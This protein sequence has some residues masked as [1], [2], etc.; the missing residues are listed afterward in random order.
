[1]TIKCW[2]YL[3]CTWKDKFAK[4]NGKELL[5]MTEICWVACHVYMLFLTAACFAAMGVENKAIEYLTN[6]RFFFM[7]FWGLANGPFA[8]SVIIMKNALVLHDLPNIAVTFIHL[9]PCSLA[10]T[11]RWF[12]PEVMA[13]FPGIFD[14]P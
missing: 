14:L 11:F 3:G 7:C 2:F 6:E 5:F 8:F 10:W 13:S 9:T 1:M 4:D 12:A